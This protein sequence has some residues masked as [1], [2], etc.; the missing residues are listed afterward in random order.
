MFTAFVASGVD[1][2][3]GGAYVNLTIVVCVASCIDSDRGGAFVSVVTAD[4][5]TSGVDSD[6]VGGHTTL[7]ICGHMGA[8][9]NSKLSV[10]L[11]LVPQRINVLHDQATFAVRPSA[12]STSKVFSSP[13]DYDDVSR[14]G[15]K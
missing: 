10:A 11:S 2:D 14:L 4:S 3:R 15:C 12:S 6:P 13:V 5:G 8:G 1:S 7:L 9:S